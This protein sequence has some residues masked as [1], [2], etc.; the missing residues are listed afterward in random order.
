L[1][2][3]YWTDWPT[4]FWI[5]MLSGGVYL[6]A[7]LTGGLPRVRRGIAISVRTE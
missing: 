2:L 1:M 5:T 7:A 4:S 6:V 3:A